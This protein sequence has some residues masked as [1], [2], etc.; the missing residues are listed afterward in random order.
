[1]MSLAKMG[2]WVN[3]SSQFLTSATCGFCAAPA[4]AHE[5][6]RSEIIMS[7]AARLARPIHKAHKN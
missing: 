6:P 1:M 3:E 7:A 5:F 2:H 4:D